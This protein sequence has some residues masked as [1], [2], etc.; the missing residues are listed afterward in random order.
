MAVFTL[1]WSIFSVRQGRYYTG[2]D[3]ARANDRLSSAPISPARA[4][5][6]PVRNYNFYLELPDVS[7]AEPPATGLH[8]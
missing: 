6:D 4:S 2:G 1:S 5:R 8:I 3:Y 7:T